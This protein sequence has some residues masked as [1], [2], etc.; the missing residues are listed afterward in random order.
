MPTKTPSIIAV[1]LAIILLILLGALAFF[2]T[3]VLLNGFS[4]NEA[5]PALGTLGICGSIGIILST[6]LA[7]QLTKLFISKYSWNSILAVFVSLLASM[8]LGTVFYII[9]MFLS[10]IVAQAVWNS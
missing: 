10:A 7:G 6:I 4:D 1:I 5:G 8:V 3:L 2:M 9:G